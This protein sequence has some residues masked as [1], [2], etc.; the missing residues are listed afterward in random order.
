MKI[1]ITEP[2]FGDE[3]IEGIKEVLASHWVVQGPKVA[4]FEQLMAEFAKTKYAFATTSCTTALHIG[5]VALGIKPGDEVIVP[6]FTFIATANVC[7]YVGAKPVFVDIDLE[8]FNIDTTKIEAAITEKTTA[9]I[10]VHLFGLAANMDEIMSLASKHKLKVLEDAACAIG[11]KYRSKHV[12]TIGEMGAVSFHP[13]KAITTGEGGMIFTQDDKLAKLSLSLRDHG[14]A[15]SDFDRHSQKAH[16]LPDFDRIGF[17]YRMTDIQGAIGVAQAHKLQTIIDGRVSRAEKYNEAFKDHQF[18]KI[19]TVPEYSNH[20]YQ[21]YVLRVFDKSPLSRD[22]IS[23]KLAEK[24]IATRQ[25]TQNV[26]CLKVYREKY[27]LKEA[28]FLNSAKAEKTTLTI[29]LYATMTDEEQ[30][31]VIDNIKLLFS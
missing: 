11:T 22:E 30:N 18:L 23:Q 24:G 1:N 17:N 31:Y 7:E 10:P 20:C 27:G 29:P 3:E 21:S 16:T 6:A 9:I 8:T 14:A 5:L 25:G 15:V 19:P 2:V 26:P 12:G 4:E 28:D 13:R